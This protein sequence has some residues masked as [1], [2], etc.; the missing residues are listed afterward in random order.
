M[1]TLKIFIFFCVSIA[2]SQ[3]SKTE[4]PNHL[5]ASPNPVQSNQSNEFLSEEYE[6]KLHQFRQESDFQAKMELIEEVLTI[7]ESI[8]RLP[9]EEKIRIQVEYYDFVIDHGLYEEADQMIDS[10]FTWLN[11]NKT[12]SGL[13]E[14]RFYVVFEKGKKHLYN[15]EYS[16]SEDLLKIAYEMGKETFGRNSLETAEVTRQMV[17]LHSY[18]GNTEELLRRADETL[19]I[20]ETIR[21]ADPFILFR[22]YASNFKHYK[23]YGDFKKMD[24]LFGKLK[25][26]YEANLYNPAF[27]HLS[28]PDY[29]H[30]NPIRSIFY[31]AELQDANAKGEVERAE[32][33]LRKFE[34][35]VQPNRNYIPFEC[36]TIISFYL[37]TGSVFHTLGRNENL[38]YYRKARKYY[39]KALDFALNQEFGFGEMQAYMML[40]MV[41][42]DYKQWDDAISFSQK[43]LANENIEKFNQ[44]ETLKHNLAMAYAGLENYDKA[45]ELLREEYIFYRKNPAKIDYSSLINLLETGDLYIKVYRKSGD[46]Q[47]LEKGYDNFFLASEIFS[48]LYRGGE[49]ST[50]LYEYVTRINSGLLMISAQLQKYQKEVLER[51]EINQSDY[52]WSSFL[53]NRSI[54]DDRTLRV[55]D[56][57]DSLRNVQRDL[58]GQIQENQEQQIPV[59]EIRDE[60]KVVEEAIQKNEQELQDYDRSFFE[61]SRTDFD[62]TRIQSNLAG[63]ERIVRY[64]MNDLSSFAYVITQ[65]EIKLIE[66]PASGADIKN[67]VNK[68]ISKLKNMDT[69]FL[70]SSSRLYEILISP[71]NIKQGYNT[72]II[73]DGFLANLPFEALS[74][75]NGDFLLTEFPVGYS[76]SLKLFEIQKHLK[77]DFKGN[78]AAFAPTYPKSES[79]KWENESRSGNYNLKGA[80][81]EVKKISSF[82]KS[83]IFIGQKAT[84]ENFL[85]ISDDFDILHLAMHA[86]VNED[87]PDLS[88][89]IFS[90]EES[91]YLNELYKMKIPAHLAVLSACNTGTGELKDGEGTQSLSRAF[92]YAGVKST[93][94]SLWQVPD[95]QTSEIMTHFYFYLKEGKTKNEALQLAKQKYLKNVTTDAL[96]HPYYWAG[97]VISGDTATLDTS[98][99]YLWVVWL[100]T[101]I[102]LIILIT[103]YRRRNR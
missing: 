80:L 96:K 53:S 64:V 98:E 45:F 9:F 16:L 54:L 85:R 56:K 3:N 84:K 36:N 37:E 51:I 78:L 70:T 35:D 74:A 10:L 17:I 24:E 57:I 87:N 95:R 27:K 8:D 63:N 34:K 61:F 26:Y 90:D 59:A 7:A 82:F 29:P 11:D 5:I 83:K 47:V 18:T 77:K 40:S 28:H 32:I 92:T 15:H 19:E 22:Q 89:L 102:L 12:I 71:L 21:P 46:K 58:A 66:L 39:K 1:K 86:N 14:E 43:A 76:N 38:E 100:A 30:L 73:P 88:N 67:D 99:N 52:L 44:T 49:F 13:D 41:S 103:L 25:G 94:M 65:K 75:T 4:K 93:V 62:I 60:L 20:Y 101:P 97:F 50:R 79:T 2:L 55:H 42:A 23:Y 81:N 33:A 91:L 69:N 6:L 72:V 68:F 48:R 31:Y